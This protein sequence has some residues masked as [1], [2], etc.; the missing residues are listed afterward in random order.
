MRPVPANPNLEERV[1][2]GPPRRKA[3]RIE[4]EVGRAGVREGLLRLCALELRG[5]SD[6]HPPP[7]RS[8]F[9]RQ[10]ILCSPVPEKGDPAN[11]Y[12]KGAMPAMM[13]AGPAQRSDDTRL[14]AAGPDVSDPEGRDRDAVDPNS[15]ERHAGR[16]WSSTALQMGYCSTK[17]CFS[18]RA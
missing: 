8:H 14:P 11:F 4:V 16:R 13:K 9:L 3:F 18:L 17:Q 6:G 1:V 10:Q 7:R 5:A 2:S 15:G 12:Y